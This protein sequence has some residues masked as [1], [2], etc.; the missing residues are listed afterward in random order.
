MSQN[1][2]KFDKF[3]T[4][5][6]FAPWILHFFLPSFILIPSEWIHEDRNLF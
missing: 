5:T 3:I 6:L 1:S 2:Y 4:V